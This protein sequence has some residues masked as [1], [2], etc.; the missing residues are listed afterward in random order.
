MDAL[1]LENMKRLNN[2]FF[3]QLLWAVIPSHGG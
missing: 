3:D 1:F 2:R